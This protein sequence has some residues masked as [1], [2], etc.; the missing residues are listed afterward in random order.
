MRNISAVRPSLFPSP[1]K[2]GANTK[3]KTGAATKAIT[4]TRVNINKRLP[5]TLL[6]VIL[7]SSLLS[8]ALISANTGTNA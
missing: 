8:C 3:A 5:A 7:R 2:P 4:V 1:E 6:T